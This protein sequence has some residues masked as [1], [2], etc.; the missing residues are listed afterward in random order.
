MDDHREIP[1][2]QGHTVP[3]IIL[4]SVYDSSSEDWHQHPNGKGWVYK[5]AH[6]DEAVYLHPTSIVYG[7]AQVYGNTRVSG[8]TQVYGNAWVYGNAQVYGNARVYGNAQVSGDARVSGNA[9]VYGNAQVYGNARVYGN[10]WVYGNAQVYGNARVYGNAWKFSIPYIQGSRHALTLC[11]LTQIAI[12]CHVHDITE[13]LKRYK[14]IGRSEGYTKDQ[15]T[16][17]GEHIA[18]LAKIAE[19]L[20]APEKESVEA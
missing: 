20:R 7:N 9:W 19:R 11:S 15:I 16:E 5:T 4:N 6:V 10:A 14:A 1:L 8:N 2:T 18:H 12:G 17:Y 13:W 3:Q